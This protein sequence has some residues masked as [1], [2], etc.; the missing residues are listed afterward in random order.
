MVCE[1]LLQRN[2][3][4]TPR[5]VGRAYA[6]LCA[7]SLTVALAFFL[8]GIWIVLAFALLEL[9]CVGLALLIYSRHALDRERIALFDGCL[10]VE[11]IR[12]EVKSQARLDPL[13]TRVIAP[14]EA[15]HTLIGLESRGVRVEVG[16]YVSEARRRQVAR[17]LRHAL[18]QRDC[19]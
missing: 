10:L 19:Y 4:L 8:R 16:R 17:E 3:S 13:W 11:S 7:M 1:W 5:Q 9:G 15:R 6:L 14:D 12:A 18:G 2:C